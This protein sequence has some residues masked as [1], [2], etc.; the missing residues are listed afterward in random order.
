MHTEMT[1]AE[2]LERIRATR[3]EWE[4]ALAAVPEGRL[5]EPGAVGEWTV[6]DVV[7]HVSYWE[8]WQADQLEALLRGE[9]ALFTRPGTPPGA[10]SDDADERNA[11]IYALYRDRPP[12]KVLDLA[13]ASYPRLL[14][15]VEQLTAQA[16][17]DH[18]TYAWT[19]GYPVWRMIAGN[20]YTHYPRHAADLHRWLAGGAG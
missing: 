17:N 3:A 20:T 19:F 6:K 15:L 5:T 16:L 18:Q 4:A 1:K 14:A 8:D 11:A 7:A 13:R 2:L 9:T 10:L 12:E